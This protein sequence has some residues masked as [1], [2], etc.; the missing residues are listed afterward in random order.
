MIRV[1]YLIVGA[2]I[3][4]IAI[5]LGILLL[6]KA[7]ESF[8]VSILGI[9]LLVFFSLGCCFILDSEIP[10]KEV[11]GVGGCDCNLWKV[12][13]E[14]AKKKGG[15]D[16]NP[17][18]DRDCLLTPPE[19]AQSLLEVLDFNP[20]ESPKTCADDTCCSPSQEVQEKNINEWHEVSVEGAEILV[21]E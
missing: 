11:K 9:P 16:C 17:I 10:L 18:T 3:V 6:L 7:E 21:D 1:T 19:K 13:L 4:A 15:L 20:F 14:E 8:V 5:A 2:L 12:L